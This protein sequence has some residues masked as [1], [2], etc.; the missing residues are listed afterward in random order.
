MNTTAP[1]AVDGLPA[2]PTEP[3]EPTSPVPETPTDVP[4]SPSD[5]QDDR[6]DLLSVVDDALSL[7]KDTTTPAE[8][9]SEVPSASEAAQP[10]TPEAEPTAEQTDQSSEDEPSGDLSDDPDQ[11]EL[12]SYKPRTRQR[13]EQLLSQRETLRKEV[14]PWNEVRGFLKESNV[15]PEDFRQGLEMLGSLGRG[16]FMGFLRGVAPY[17]R[18]AQEQAGLTL[19]GDLQQRVTAKQI[20]PEQA[21]ELAKARHDQ[22]RAESEAALANRRA[23]QVALTSHGDNIRQAVDHWEAGVKQ[24]DPD[25]AAKAPVI[26]KY[27]LAEMSERGAPRTP[28]E[29][30]AL[31]Q[32]VYQEVSDMLK[33]KG[34]SPQ[35][36]RPRVSGAGTPTNSRAAPQSLMDAVNFGIER[37]RGMN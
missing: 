6:A 30:L 4:A 10:A 34:V 2:E 5:A 17:V 13:I 12:D 27:V 15:R 25:Y 24:T 1:P 37:A 8:P 20:T 3:T 35:Q 19:P 23:D 32:R 36:T 11:A 33:P 14:E 21:R 9:A 28:Q 26:R 22:M 16:D 31:S 18:L 7:H 29:A